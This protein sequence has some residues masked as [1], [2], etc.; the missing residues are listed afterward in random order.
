M[1]DKLNEI[2]QIHTNQNI[3]RIKADTDRDFY[4]SGEEAKDYGI[5][6]CVIRTRDD[7]VDLDKDGGN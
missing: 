4:L 3:E 5:I 6:D 2:L 1:K 7:I